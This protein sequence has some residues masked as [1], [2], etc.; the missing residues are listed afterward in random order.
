MVSAIKSEGEVDLL[1]DV[2][3]LNQVDGVDGETI[4]TTLVGDEGVSEE[5][6]GDSLSFI[7]GA[8]ELDTTLETGFLDVTH[9]T[10]TT[11][12]LGLDDTAATWDLASDSVGFIRGERDVTEG[13]GNI[14]G[15]EKGTCLVFVKFQSTHRQRT[16]L[17][18]G[19]L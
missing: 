1:L 8:D 12:N 3:L 10:A 18:E 19:S 7:G 2:D 5:L 4:S 17:E 16:V 15:A 6:S 14:V 11:E 9:A 13:G